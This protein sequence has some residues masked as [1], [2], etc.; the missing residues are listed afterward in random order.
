MEPRCPDHEEVVPAVVK[1][2]DLVELREGADLVRYGGR[3]DL[4]TLRIA[5]MPKVVDAARQSRIMVL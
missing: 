3:P 4:V 2:L 1:L 5:T